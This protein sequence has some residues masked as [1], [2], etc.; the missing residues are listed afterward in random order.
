MLAK[1][2]SK[3]IQILSKNCLAFSSSPHKDHHDHLEEHHDHDH[4]HHDYSVHI[5]KD[6]PWIKYKSVLT[7]LYRTLNSSASSELKILTINC[8][9]C[10]KMIPSNT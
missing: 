10:L 3:R 4:H 2:L 9:L 6:S 1:F 8:N 7:S 5:D